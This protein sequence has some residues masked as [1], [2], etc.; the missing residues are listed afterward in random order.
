MTNSVN[1]VSCQKCTT[2]IS[3]KATAAIFTDEDWSSE[4]LEVD[5][6]MVLDTSEIEA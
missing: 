4:P 1:F 6:G 5:C 2:R 3:D